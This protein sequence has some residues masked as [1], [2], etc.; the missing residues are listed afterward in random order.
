MHRSSRVI[1]GQPVLQIRAVTLSSYMDVARFVG[2]DGRSLLR[3]HGIALAAL[4]DPEARISARAAARLLELSAKRSGVDSFGLR[5]AEC[6]SFSSIGPIALLLQHLPNLADTVKCLAL[7]QRRVSD[8]VQVS[9]EEQGGTAIVRFDVD[10]EIR[11]AQSIDLQVAL[12]HLVL[13]AVSQ[14]AWRP[15]AIHLTRT[16]PRDVEHF[17]RHFDAPLEF[18]S[19]FNGF[20]CSPAALLGPLPLAEPNMAAHA[21][22][23]LNVPQQTAPFDSL[24]D[25]VR[26]SVAL[27]LPN[28]RAT[29][30]NVAANLGLTKRTLQRKLADQDAAFAVLLNEV[31]RNLAVRY[32]SGTRRAISEVAADLG[33]AEVSSF[34][35]WFTSDFGCAP[36]AWRNKD[37]ASQVPPAMWKVA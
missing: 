5:M 35:R 9:A 6:R 20:S 24:L 11:G 12:G 13:K 29:A 33:Y 27:L 2:I 14:G 3:E 22:S 7:L 26:Q 28:G 18:D 1:K 23:L 34:T 32:L 16:A 36:S 31:R 17:R 10:P 25:H 4:E 21:R 15:D 8:I 30:E 37:T 19:G